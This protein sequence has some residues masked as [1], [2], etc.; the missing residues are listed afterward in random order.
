MEVNSRIRA[1]LD[2]CVLYP[3]PVRDLHLS[4]AAEGL[5]DPKWTTRIH[6]EWIF[7]L[8][9]K[10]PD[11]HRQQLEL[12][13]KYMDT[14]FPNANINHYEQLIESV[15]LPYADDRHVLAAAIQCKAEIIVTYNLRDFPDE[16]VQQYGIGVCH[17]D[18]F[19]NHHYEWNPHKGAVAFQKMVDRLRRPSKSKQEVIDLLRRCGLNEIVT[20]LNAC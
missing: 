4:F 18:F 15:E 12:T 16:V 9:K 2:A 14:A 13:R 1:L 7:N 20:K 6:E 10:R 3:A 11:L 5:F 19:L 17:P 8:L